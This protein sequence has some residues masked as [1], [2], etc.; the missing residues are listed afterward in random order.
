MIDNLNLHYFIVSFCIGLLV[1][2]CTHPKKHIVH[3][4][5]SPNGT[6]TVYNGDDNCYKFEAHEVE[7]SQNA[8]PQPIIEGFKKKTVLN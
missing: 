3:K 5:P 4:F 7:C 2:N 6:H 8:K 1:V